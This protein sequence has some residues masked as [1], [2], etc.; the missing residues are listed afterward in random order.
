MIKV[1]LSSIM[2][3]VTIQNVTTPEIQINSEEFVLDGRKQPPNTLKLDRKLSHSSGEVDSGESTNDS[4][5]NRNLGVDEECANVKTLNY[6]KECVGNMSQSQ[7]ESAL[8]TKLTNLTSPVANVT[9][10][11]VTPL[12]KL[13]KG[14]QNFGANLDPRKIA[15]GVRVPNEME[16]EE[17]RQVVEKWRDRKSRIIAL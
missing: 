3:N 9:K 8:K 14:V 4:H 6:D 15:I 13:A 2:D 5:F 12:S 16:M 7:S 10:G 11:L 17:H 1:Q